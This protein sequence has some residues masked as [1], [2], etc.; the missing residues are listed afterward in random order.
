MN[1]QI[2]LNINI[3]FN[4]MINQ[5]EDIVKVKWSNGVPFL[6]PILENGM[7]SPTFLTSIQVVQIY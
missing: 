3:V 5:K 7:I 2:I 4:I 1:L 6:P